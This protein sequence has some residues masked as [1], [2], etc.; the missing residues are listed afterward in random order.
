MSVCMT[1][2]AHIHM[3]IRTHIHIR[4]HIHIRT[5]IHAR[6]HTCTTAVR[7]EMFGWKKAPGIMVAVA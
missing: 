1:S 4:I 6:T 3:H 7:A 2:D 5:H